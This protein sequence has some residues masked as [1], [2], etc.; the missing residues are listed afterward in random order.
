MKARSDFLLEIG[1]EEIPASMI[2]KAVGE[3]Q[4]TLEKYL[5]TANLLD[6]SK[7]ECFGAPRRLASMIS[8]L[9][10]LQTD[11]IREVTGPPKSVAYDA[12]G[13]PTRAAEGF[14]AKQGVPVDKLYVVSTQRGEQ[15]AAK[16]IERGRPASQ[17]LAEILPRAIREIPWP[18][19]MYW[20]TADGIRF[21]RPIR[22]LVALLDGKP[23]HF[24]LDGLKP[25]SV[26]TGHRFLGKPH[27]K[28]TGPRDYERR[29]R[30]NFVLVRPA[31][32]RKKIDQEIRAL[33]SRKQLRAHPDPALLDLVTYLNE[34][35]SVILGDFDPGYLDLPREILITVMR[36][37][38]KYFA[39]EDAHGRLAPHFLA[40]IN[41]AKDSAG[42]VR[43]GHERVLRARFADA[44]FFW[45]TDQKCRLADYLPRLA[46]VT[47]ESRLGSYLEKVERVRWIARWLAEQW[48]NSGLPQSSVAAADRAAE[49][50]KCDLATDMVR[51]FTEL[52]G[53]VGGL[54]AKAQ[55]EPEEVCW[56]IYDHYRP[57]GLDDPIPRN[58]TGC[59][60]AV[61]DKL[62][63][64][65]GC[66]AA[67]LIPSG[68]SDP[69][70]LRRAALGIVK[71][72]LERRLPLSLSATLA[73]AGKSLASHPPKIRLSA[74][75]E[76]QVMEFL[77][78]RTKYIFRERLGFAYDEVNAVLS[79]GAD[80]LV[81]AVKR[82]EALKAIR[83]TKNFE[84]LAVSFKRIRK[85]LE[86]AGP[87][88]SWRASSVQAGFMRDE[89]ERQLHAAAGEVARRAEE[90]KRAGKYREALQ[91]IAD[92][93]PAVDR[94]FDEVLV[95]APEED[96]RK[97]RLTLLAGLLSQF[98]TIADFSE[99]ATEGSR[100]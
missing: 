21:I 99:I 94:F 52:Q 64:L 29:L 20:T 65:V 22:W 2:A 77:L 35:P 82:L 13:K 33:T 11:V 63:S 27:V 96:V 28:V 95:M 69:F 40:V 3:L 15:L 56:A 86:K 16:L 18:R 30:A 49:L 12:D 32:R 24:E 5:T 25:G 46:F 38:Q 6:N 26:S 58:L 7:I 83:R 44:R 8:G 78:E 97:N 42:L 54:Y 48:F 98:S 10:S 53:I 62:D 90:L 34:W 92:L 39:V 71:I 61:A 14:A 50:A 41:L 9:R 43:A 47:Y 100:S 74:E 37:H 70:A 80:D 91:E 51:E 1:C 45:R 73:A 57:A 4:V 72:I 55:E 79:A 87:A 88:L 85:I 76:K 93:R 75:V 84:P 67:G 59:A 36:G 68:S 17:I 31:D 19:S 23:L 60:V 66:F 81:D 89:A